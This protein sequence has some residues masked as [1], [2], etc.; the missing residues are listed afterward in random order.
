MG[1]RV[2]LAVIFSI[3]T[4]T[5]AVH[6]VGNAGDSDPSVMTPTFYLFKI[7]YRLFF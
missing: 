5:G 2:D 3:N 7:K 4:G 6:M 1:K